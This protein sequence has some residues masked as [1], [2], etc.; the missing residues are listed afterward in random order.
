MEA[1]YSPPPAAAP[2]CTTLAYPAWR[3][4]LPRRGLLQTLPPSILPPPHPRAI[5]RFREGTERS[6]GRL[7]RD[8]AQVPGGCVIGLSGL[9]R[10]GLE[11]KRY[12]VVISLGDSSKG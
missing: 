1:F 3:L 10:S 11:V 2:P 9:E 7:P 5:E 4:R 12:R 8:A 6:S